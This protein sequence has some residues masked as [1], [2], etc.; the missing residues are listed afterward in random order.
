MYF[1]WTYYNWGL[2][3]GG[4]VL[5]CCSFM[6]LSLVWL[7]TNVNITT[8]T[9]KSYKWILPV[10][11]CRTFSAYFCRLTD[12]TI[13]FLKAISNNF[14]PTSLWETLIVN[15]LLLLCMP[16]EQQNNNKTSNQTSSLSEGISCFAWQLQWNLNW[17]TFFSSLSSIY[18]VLTNNPFTCM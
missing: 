16:T 11:R 10:A 18:R 3:K 12:I 2:P 1:L 6:T 4:L 17:T 7:G 9:K 14:L 8:K 5:V 13:I 15:H